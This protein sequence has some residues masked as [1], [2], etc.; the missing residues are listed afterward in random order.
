MIHGSTL[1][2]KAGVP[3][4]WEPNHRWILAKYCDPAEIS[5]TDCRN[6]F[7]ESMHAQMSGW[8][9]DDPRT[10]KPV[11]KPITEDMR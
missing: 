6:A 8:R 5:C 9:D 10:K 11:P 3:S 4:S 2:R 1:C 7:K